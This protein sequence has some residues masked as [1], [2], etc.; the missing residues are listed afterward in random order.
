MVVGEELEEEEQWVVRRRAGLRIV[1]G[2]LP[3]RLEVGGREE[4]NDASAA[5]GASADP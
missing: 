5:A 3:G 2:L 1:G 4:C